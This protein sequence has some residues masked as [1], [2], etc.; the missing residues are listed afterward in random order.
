M[1]LPMICF[2]TRWGWV[3]NTCFIPRNRPSNYC[4][5]Q[6]Y[7][8]LH[9]WIGKLKRKVHLWQLG[10]DGKIVKNWPWKMHNC[11]KLVGGP[12]W[13][14]KAFLWTWQQADSITTRGMVLPV[15]ATTKANVYKLSMPPPP[16]LSKQTEVSAC[17]W[18]CQCTWMCM[19]QITMYWRHYQRCAIKILG[20]FS[21]HTAVSSR[22][23]SMIT[24]VNNWLKIYNS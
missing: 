3:V 17:I 23:V 14:P 7:T 12:L 20:T 21:V 19:T 24:T 15:F 4:K 1:A 6:K 2:S 8:V 16:H 5:L 18:K 11:V 13:D 10:T 22:K 9:I